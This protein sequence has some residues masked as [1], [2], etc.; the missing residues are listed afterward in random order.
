[1]KYHRTSFKSFIIQGI[2]G[3]NVAILISGLAFIGS[4]LIIAPNGG[5]FTPIY[6]NPHASRIDHEMQV[7]LW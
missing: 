5:Q 1:M 6:R 2:I 3:G 4:L 7:V